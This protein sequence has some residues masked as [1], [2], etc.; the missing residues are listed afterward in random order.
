[1]GHSFA[2]A[3]VRIAFSGNF[4]NQVYKQQIIHPRTEINSGTISVVQFYIHFHVI[5]PAL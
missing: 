3:T 2:T 5:L 4:Q 1:M